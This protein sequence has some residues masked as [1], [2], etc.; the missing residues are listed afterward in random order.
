MGR[1]EGGKERKGAREGRPPIHIPAVPVPEG[2]SRVG[3]SLC[4]AA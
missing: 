3:F 2:R 1:G 4:E